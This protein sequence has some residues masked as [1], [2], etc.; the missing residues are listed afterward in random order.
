MDF[1]PGDKAVCPGHGVGE[2]VG[3]ETK[4]VAGKEDRF[5]VIQILDNNMKIMIPTKQANSSR[6]R[7]IISYETAQRVIDILKC[8][9]VQA[10][11]QQTWNRRFR[12]YTEKIKTGKPEEIATV[13][14][15]L[16]RLKADKELSFGERKLLDTA[17][18]LLV[19]ELAI[20]CATTEPAIETQISAALSN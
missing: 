5:Y 18:Q 12:E 10:E 8:R 4:T 11:S 7:G 2:V 6:L 14:R 13:M 17:R 15:D 1:M 3:V 19:K 9:E 20:A 16:S